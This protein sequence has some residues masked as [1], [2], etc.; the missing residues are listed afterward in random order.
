MTL[1]KEDIDVLK[2]L[3]KKELSHVEKDDKELLV[4]NAGFITKTATATNL[5]F[6]KA[7]P[8]YEK[9]LKDLLKKL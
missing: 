8:L 9:F 3:I 2:M 4:S 6:L 5:N 7:I 1:K